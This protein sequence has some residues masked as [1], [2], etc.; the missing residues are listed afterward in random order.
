MA[1]SRPPR[2]RSGD[3]EEETQMEKLMSQPR[4]TFMTRAIEYMLMPDIRTVMKAKVMADSARAAFAEA[5]LQVAGHG[6]GLR[7]VVEGHHDD[8]QEEHGGDGADP[9]P[10]GGEHAVLDRRRR[11]SP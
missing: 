7:D 8:A 3:G 5:E 6:V 4:T 1:E 2:R 10:V 11:P 9:I